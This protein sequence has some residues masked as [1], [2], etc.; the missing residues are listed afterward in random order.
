M[1][2]CTNCGNKLGENADVC[3]KCG[4]V[5][6][7]KPQ[8]KK[9]LPVW[10][11]VLIVIGAIILLPIILLVVG[12][13]IFN[14]KSTEPVDY[15]DYDDYYDDYYDDDY[16]Y[17]FNYGTV[18]ETL[19]TGKLS[20]TLNEYKE[21]ENVDEIDD[22]YGKEYLILYFDVK[23]E[24]SKTIKISNY[25]FNAFCDSYS[26]PIKKLDF[27]DDVDYLE[28]KIEPG[29][30]ISGYIAFLVD[31]DWEDFEVSYNNYKDDEITFYVYNNYYVN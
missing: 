26:V 2:Y 6:N 31:S 13:I 4:K 22:S 20:F 24:S 1:K 15:D 21:S 8:K 30:T 28:G 27:I 12:Y 14:I 19:D 11:I 7:K 3:L 10:A 29:E 5:F 23:N 9:G 16:D 18:G 17:T 25:D